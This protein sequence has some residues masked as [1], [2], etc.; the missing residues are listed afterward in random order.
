MDNKGKHGEP[1]TTNKMSNVNVAIIEKADDTDVGYDFTHTDADRI[2]ACVNACDGMENPEQEIPAM[3]SEIARLK[4]CL[5][6][7]LNLYYKKH[8]RGSDIKK[9]TDKELENRMN[10]IGKN[11]FEIGPVLDA[12]KI[13]GIQIIKEASDG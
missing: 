6:N 12:R 9:T 3:R 8:P 4:E 11:I 5:L 2:I 1:W 10:I 7:M 13:L